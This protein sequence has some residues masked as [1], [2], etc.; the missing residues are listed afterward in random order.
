MSEG[1]PRCQG[2]VA[3]LGEPHPGTEGSEPQGVW[4]V[5]LVGQGQAM[6]AVG[7]TISCVRVSQA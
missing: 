7:N 6:G 3:F 4:L 5:G 1:E 2:L